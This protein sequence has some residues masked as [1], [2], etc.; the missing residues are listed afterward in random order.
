MILSFLFIHWYISIFCQTFFLHRY[1]SHQMFT[2]SKRWEKFFFFITWLTQGTSFLSPRAYGVM[3]KL[4][5]KHSDQKQDPHS[6]L[7]FKDVMS[8]MLETY[9][10]YLNIS[11]GKTRYPELEKNA[12]QW[13]GFEKFA[14]NNL[15]RALFV[16][17]YASFYLFF[18]S[19]L[20]FLLLVPVHALMGPIHGAIVNWCGHKYG[21]RN[22]SLDDHSKNTSPLDFITLGELMQ[23]NHH[24][25]PN[26]LCFAKKWFEFDLGYALTMLLKKFRVITMIKES[27]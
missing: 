4:H 21:Y 3:H 23:N 15:V 14:D 27:S 8:M 1:T 6:P 16:L 13:A 18:T 26:S 19:S 12:P 9:R 20:W 22:Y 24:K 5:H 25:F 2:M 10:I 17:A 7:F 11:K